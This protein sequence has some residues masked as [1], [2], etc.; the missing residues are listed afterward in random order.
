MAALTECFEEVIEIPPLANRPK[1]I[2]PLAEEFLKRHGPD[3]PTI[4]EGAR[5]ALL[6]LR[7]RRRNVAELR[8]VMDLA[9]RV[10]DGPEIRAE[11]IFGGVGEDAA[12]PG[13]DITA[14]PLIAGLLRRTG[15]PL[16]R[17]ATLAGFASVIVL[18][19]AAA[20]S[21][22]GRFANTAIWSVWEPA[23]FALFFL[24][25]PVWC[26]ICPLSSAASWLSKKAGIVEQTAPSA[27]LIVKHGPWMAIVG[28]ALIIWVERVFDTLAKPRGIGYPAPLVDRAR[29]AL[30]HALQT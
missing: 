1:D 26:T 30:R 10:A 22:A 27:W 14:T 4:T 8:E 15:L 9:V 23:V 24:A 29:G 21:A 11:H 20:G 16:L 5:Q 19:L 28:F 7:Y 13:V 25:G 2:L 12:P 18:C 17:G 3:A 6:S